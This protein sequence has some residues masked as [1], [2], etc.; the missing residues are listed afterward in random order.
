[1][2]R[3]VRM[4]TGEDGNSLF[5]E[6]TLELNNIAGGD[7][8]TP[9]IAVNELTF[10]ET[11]SGGSF[12]WHQDPVPR[13]VITL[14]GTLEFETKDG[15]K[16]II[17]PGDILLAQDNTGTGH[18]WRLIGDEPWRRAYVVYQEDTDLCFTP[19]QK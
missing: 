14:S 3:C 2:I 18:K 5:E 10:R 19:T 12:D 6:G 9:T 7:S 13:Y 16:F 15:S 17:N 11:V 4:W 1:M 8:Q